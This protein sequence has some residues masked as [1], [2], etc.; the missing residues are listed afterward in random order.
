MFF[1]LSANDDVP[2]QAPDSKDLAAW[3]KVGG[4][5]DRGAALADPPNNDGVS[6]GKKTLWGP[7]HDSKDAAMLLKPGFIIHA[8]NF[9]KKD[10]KAMIQEVLDQIK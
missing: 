4:W 9:S 7:E 3:D 10:S 5:G 6:I 2:P 1:L 8:I